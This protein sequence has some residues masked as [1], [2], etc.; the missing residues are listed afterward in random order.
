MR[1]FLLRLLTYGY[2]LGYSK[3][4]MALLV[5]T[6]LIGSVSTI[7]AAQSTACVFPPPTSC[8]SGTFL[9]TNGCATNPSQQQACCATTAGGSC[10]GGSGGTGGTGTISSQAV[11]NEIKSICT[12][13]KTVVFIL[14]LALMILGG[15]LYAGAHVM[16]G[17]TKGQI[18]GY[19]MGMLVGGVIGVIIAL[20]APFV[21]N[22]IITFDSAA[23]V[24][25]VSC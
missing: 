11:V 21:L 4:F 13:I 19:G 20:I 18:Q 8:A 22:Q 5:V 6:G 15:A 9:S 14:G 17:A 16:P 23:G 2:T 12:S 25:T 1:K 3:L 7:A 10:T 24:S